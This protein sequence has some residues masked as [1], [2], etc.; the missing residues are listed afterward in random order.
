VLADLI[1]IKDR[2]EA[3]THYKQ[4]QSSHYSPSWLRLLDDGGQDPALTQP[5][6]IALIALWRP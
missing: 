2:T 4:M 3:M 1:R 6:L 5:Q